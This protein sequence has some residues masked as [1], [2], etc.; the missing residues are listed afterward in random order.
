ML[1]LLNV[2][3]QGLADNSD[4]KPTIVH[5]NCSER[6]SS[7]LVAKNQTVLEI[8]EKHLKLA[9]DV[10]TSKSCTEDGL[11]DATAF[12]L[13]LSSGPVETRNMVSTVLK[14]TELANVAFCNIEA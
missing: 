13:N 12:L 4:I 11:D 7:A 3:A 6:A 8:P 1:R 2:A 5:E 14:F 10:L 9:I